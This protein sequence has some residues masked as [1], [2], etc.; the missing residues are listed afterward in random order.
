MPNYIICENVKGFLT[1]EMDDGRKYID[2]IVSKFDNLGYKIK[3]KLF[4]LFLIL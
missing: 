2:V 4:T 1:G 3:Y